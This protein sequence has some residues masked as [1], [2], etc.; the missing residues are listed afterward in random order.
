VLVGILA[1][2]DEGLLASGMF[3][4]LL[5]AVITGSIAVALSRSVN[6]R[7]SLV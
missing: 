1:T 5:V 3:N 7:M 2:G 6:Q 4:I